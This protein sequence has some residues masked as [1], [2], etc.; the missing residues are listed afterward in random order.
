MAYAASSALTVVDNA[1]T[2]LRA[3]RDAAQAGGAPAI[4]A[5]LEQA[6]ARI[7]ASRDRITASGQMSTWTA[8]KAVAALAAAS[9]PARVDNDRAIVELPSGGRLRITA[10]AQA[11]PDNPRP[12]YAIAVV[13]RRGEVATTLRAND[14]PSLGNV[15]G[16]LYAGAS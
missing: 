15:A 4:A 13:G 2:A 14:D 1:V 10:Y 9:V 8:D 7:S 5:L 3:E 12:G 16:R 11:F 6:A